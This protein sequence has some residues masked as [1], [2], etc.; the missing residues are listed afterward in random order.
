MSF[1]SGYVGGVAISKAVD[2]LGLQAVYSDEELVLMSDLK[3][4]VSAGEVDIRELEV[5]HELKSLLGAR[6]VEDVVRSGRPELHAERLRHAETRQAPRNCRSRH[7]GL[8]GQG[9]FFD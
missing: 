9:S 2:W 4:G 1:G 5:L 6:M 7:E 8:V 3:A